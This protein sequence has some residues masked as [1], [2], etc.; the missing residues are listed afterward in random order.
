MAFQSSFAQLSRNVGEFTSIK[1]YDKISVVLIPSNESKVESQQSDV[2]VVNN[3][4][5]L[6][7]RMAATRILQGDQVSVNVYYQHLND[8]QASQSSSVN[9]SEHLEARML[10]LT[11]N[12]G[13]RINLT[14]ETGTLNI[15]INSGGDITVA[16]QADHQ[17]IVVN[18][19]GKFNGKNLEAKSAA[20]TA[21][22]GGIA[23]VYASESVNAKTRAG[24]I[25]D[26]YGD[27]EDRQYKTV[28]GGKINFK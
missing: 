4:G 5:E 13:S 3:N 7:I 2:E 15:K 20:V 28:I 9:S 24:G 25:I 22:A 17:D 26:V 10:G 16:G 6:K 27:P 14:L 23:E 19:G 8:I 1:V 21:N 18:S 11:A 12:E